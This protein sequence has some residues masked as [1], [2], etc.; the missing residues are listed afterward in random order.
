MAITP[1]VLLTYTATG[2]TFA[3]ATANNLAI[4][5]T[6]SGLGTLEEVVQPVTL[7]TGTI[8]SDDT[9][10]Q[11]TGTGTAFLTDF[12]AGQYLF[13][14][15]ETGEPAL[16]GKIASIASNVALALTQNAAVTQTDVNCGMAT[17]IM[18]TSEDI[19]IR[20]PVVLNG[21]GNAIIPNWIAYIDSVTGYNNAS[22]SSLEQYSVVTEPYTP[23]PSTINVEYTILPV[24]N[25]Q[26]YETVVGGQKVT[27]LFQSASNFPSFCYAVFNPYGDANAVLAPNT[28]YKLF[29]NEQFQLNGVNV[30]TAYDPQ[31]L[32]LAGY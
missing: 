21:N 3:K 24:Y 15:D 29:A 20:I 8:V 26:S 25:F 14:Y 22:N 1:P 6:Q 17:T 28:L 19:L 7:A 5:N 23:A 30:T 13:Y 11:I 18:G 2:I 31:S 32:K 9:D 12:K 4:A 16:L 27:R 10:T